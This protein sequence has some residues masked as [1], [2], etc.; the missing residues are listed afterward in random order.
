MVITA[1]FSTAG[2]VNASLYP[3]T[4]MT[5]HLADVGQFPPVFGRNVGRVP[6]SDSS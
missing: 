3:S 6:R 4:G 5:R 1:L 2:A